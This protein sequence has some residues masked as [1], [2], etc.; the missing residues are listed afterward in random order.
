MARQYSLKLFFILL[1]TVIF[2]SFSLFFTPKVYAQTCTFEG[3][4]PLVTPDPALCTPYFPDL[5]A[6]PPCN[7]EKVCTNKAFKA[8]NIGKPNENCSV[9]G[10]LD[11]TGCCEALGRDFCD[12]RD[13]GD[14]GVITQYDFRCCNIPPNPNPTPTPK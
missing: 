5:I 2:F 6:Y 12:Q 3:Y 13:L 10:K 1:S 9:G 14:K 11:G 8:K 4:S 7:S